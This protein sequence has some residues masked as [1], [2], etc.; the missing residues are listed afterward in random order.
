MGC[1]PDQHTVIL[2]PVLVFDGSYGLGK[3]SARKLMSKIKRKLLAKMAQ[4][5]Y[6]R[7]MLTEPIEMKSLDYF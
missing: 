4:Y 5:G 2:Y 3:G 6:T 1:A 7:K